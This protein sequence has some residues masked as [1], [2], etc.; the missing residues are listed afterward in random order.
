M[1]ELINKLLNWEGENRYKL[2]KTYEFMN[3]IVV[4][5]YNL[6]FLFF[7]IFAYRH[8]MDIREFF[9]LPHTTTFVDIWYCL[10]STTSISYAYILYVTF[11]KSAHNTSIYLYKEE[12]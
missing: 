5:L 2:I 12:A 4:K 8:R 3:D 9:Y 7:S 6:S 1:C 10:R 11:Y